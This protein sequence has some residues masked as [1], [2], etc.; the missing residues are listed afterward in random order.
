[1]HI[2]M[3]LRGTFPHDIRV[4]KEARSLVAGGHEVSLLCLSR[5]NGEPARERVGP[6]AVHRIPRRERYTPPYRTYK[7]VRY[8]LTLD[9]VIWRAEID[10]FVDDVGVDVLHVHDLPLVRTAQSVADDRGLPLVADLHENY[11]EAAR[12][13]RTGMA[14]PRRLVQTLF[15]PYRRLRALE[16]DCVRAADHVLATTPEGRAHY[17]ADCGADPRRVSVVSNT[18]DLATYDTAVDPAEGFDDEFVVSYVGSF[19]PHRG[20]EPLIDALPALVERVPNAR[21]LLVGSAGEAAYER[22]LRERAAATGVGNRVTFTGWIDLEEVPRYVAASDVCTVPHAENPHTATTVPHK[23][24]QYMASRKPVLVSE[25]PTLARVVNDADCGI[26]VPEG[27]HE[28]VAAELTTLAEDPARRKRLG[29][30]GR[31]AVERT[32]NWKR[33]GGRLDAVYREL[34][35]VERRSEPGRRRPER[36]SQ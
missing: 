36:A 23:L 18:V 21:L 9:D 35:A 22:R 19:G 16:R 8:L 13:W 34:D 14:L 32:Y 20:L 5:E 33:E 15:T 2:G 30:N 6:I 24:F 11:P 12:Q 29:T 26:V 1:M 17:V 31:V 25:V 7:T 27:D 10:R 4:E 3:V 28:A